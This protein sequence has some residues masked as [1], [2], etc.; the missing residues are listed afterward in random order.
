MSTE[1]LRLSKLLLYGPPGCGKTSFASG[2]F[3]EAAEYNSGWITTKLVASEIFLNP[4]VNIKKAFDA[5]Q[6]YHIKGL[7]IEDVDELFA[8]LRSSHLAAY[9]LLL[10]RMQEVNDLQLIIATARNPEALSNRELE[11]FKAILPV[12]Y[13]DE[14]DRLDILRVLT[15]DINLEASISLE[16]VAERT[17]WWSGGELKELIERS[18]SANSLIAGGALLQSIDDINQCVDSERRAERMNALLGFTRKYCNIKEMRDNLLARHADLIEDFRTET[19]LEKGGRPLEEDSAPMHPNI[20][21]LIDRMSDALKRGDYSGVLHSSASIFE[22]LAKD[23]VGVPTVQN[24]TL[25]S[26]FER[27]RKDSA[28][29]DKILD[30]ILNVYE[31]RNITPLAGHGST[32]TPTISKEVA[33]A[34]SE[35]TKAFVRIEYM[36]Y[37]PLKR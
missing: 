4:V 31:S 3:N 7:M 20:R 35:M 28:L 22:T 25:K 18:R 13:P 32:Q 26:F 27:Y 5:I 37:K 29:P 15:R 6:R 23:V 21:T 1:G 12:L 36:L 8:N 10:E 14:E 17:R 33:V 30:Y 34:L 19:P 11:L 2:C 16:A 9:Q 24:Q